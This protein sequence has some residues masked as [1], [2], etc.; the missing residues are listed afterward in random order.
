MSKKTTLVVAAAIELC[1]GAY[2]TLAFFAWCAKLF[3]FSTNRNQPSAMLLIWLALAAACF[4]LYRRTRR[5]TKTLVENEAHAQ[6]IARIAEEIRPSQNNTGSA[7]AD[8]HIKP[9]I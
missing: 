1:L 9:A 3:I 2:F 7:A 6:G 5:K 8:T 4:V